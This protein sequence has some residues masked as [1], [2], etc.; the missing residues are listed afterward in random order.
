VEA[1]RS[2]TAGNAR[3]Y[4]ETLA[5]RTP[6][7]VWAIQAVSPRRTGAPG[8]NGVDGGREFMTEFEQACAG[9]VIHLIVLAPRS[10]RLNGHITAR[11]DSFFSLV[12][13]QPIQE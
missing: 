12:G 13:Q 9:K 8:P 11:R 4:L 7:P 3:R 6:F 2:A 10:P 5:K 1:C